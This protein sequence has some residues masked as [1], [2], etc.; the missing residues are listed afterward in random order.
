M[1]LEEVV[2]VP[3]HLLLGSLSTLGVGNKDQSRVWVKWAEPQPT[4]IEQH[5]IA[6]FADWTAILN[7]I[8][9]F[10]VDIL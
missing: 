5:Y 6:Y 4:F 8:I 2:A 10:Y 9:M 3:T 1:Q 7:G